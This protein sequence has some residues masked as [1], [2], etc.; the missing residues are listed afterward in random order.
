MKKIVEEK[1]NVEEEK[2]NLVCIF[3]DEYENKKY[4]LK[5]IIA[6]TRAKFEIKGS[7]SEL[8]VGNISYYILAFRHL[9]LVDV[10]YETL[11]NIIRKIFELNGQQCN[12]TAKSQAWYQRKIK[13]GDVD[14]HKQFKANVRV[15]N[16][17]DISKLF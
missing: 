16:I 1:K 7:A 14:I 3:G 2:K 15:K 17:V 12:T 11:A 10:S 13:N 5:E 9:K 6:M 8:P 4:E